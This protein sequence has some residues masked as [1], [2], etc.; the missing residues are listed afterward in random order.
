MPSGARGEVEADASGL[1]NM[2]G[3]SGGGDA[4]DNVSEGAGGDVGIGG[5]D[6]SGIG[7]HP[8]SQRHEEEYYTRFTARQGNYK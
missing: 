3:P 6:P 7:R 2:E 8:L 4:L 5:E 1:G